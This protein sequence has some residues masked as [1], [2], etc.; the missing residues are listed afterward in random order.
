MAKVFQLSNIS[1]RARR[2][3]REFFWV[4]LGQTAAVLGAIVGIRLLTHAL[5]PATYGELALGLTMATLVQ[6][7]ILGPLAGSSLR[8]FA[9]AQ[10]ANQIRSYIWGVQRLL[11][12][13]TIILLGLAT[14][15]I[16]GLWL[17]GERQWL[18]FTLAALV[19]AL[20]SGYSSALDG[21]Q[22][23]ARQR[24]IVAWHDGLAVWLRFLIAVALVSAVGAFSQVAVVGYALASALVLG[25]QFWFFRRRIFALSSSEP[26]A[27]LVQAQHWAKQMRSYAWPFATWGL[28][29]WAQLASDRWALQTFATTRDVGLYAVLY[30]MGYYPISMISALISQLV[31]PIFFSRAGD[32]SDPARL[33]RVQHANMR[34]TLVTIG[35][36]AIASLITLFS[37]D[38]IFAGFTAPEYHSVSWLLPLVVLSSGLFAAGQLALLSLLARNETHRL[39]R[40]KITI[41]LLGALLNFIGARLFGLQG[42]VWAGLLTSCAYLGWTLLLVVVALRPVDSQFGSRTT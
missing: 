32:G 19:F 10:E 18:G 8:F 27:A 42:V 33:L 2:V 30:Q 22:N 37:H 26:P 14:L 41:A 34:L 23:A 25:S 24:A 12:Q 29:T 1:P 36:S 3:G 6:Q 17:S 40:F 16:V 15:L 21:M 9:P 39:I 38:A 20:F 11:L 13:A 31:A 5:S 35:L 28:F 4:G 7:V